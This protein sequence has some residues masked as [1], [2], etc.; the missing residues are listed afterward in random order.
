[1]LATQENRTLPDIGLTNK[2]LLELRDA[3]NLKI[4]DAIF[5]RRLNENEFRTSL[6]EDDI[7]MLSGPAMITEL[8][9]SLAI[10]GNSGY[11]A[12]NSAE[13]PNNE[14]SRALSSLGCLCKRFSSLAVCWVATYTRCRYRSTQ[15]PRI[16]S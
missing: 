9:T 3:M 8:I 12:K 6:T 13:S 5:S 2:T 11:L 15:S 7:K 16:M 10:I 14:T 1:M 4:L